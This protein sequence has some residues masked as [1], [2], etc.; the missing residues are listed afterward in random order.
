MFFRRKSTGSITHKVAAGKERSVGLRSAKITVGK[1]KKSTIKLEGSYISENHAVVDRTSDGDWKIE[2]LSPN[3]VIVNGSKVESAVLRNGD[4]IQ[5][6]SDNVLTIRGLSERDGSPPQEEAADDIAEQESAEGKSSSNNWLYM[7]AG[8]IYLLFFGYIAAVYFGDGQLLGYKKQDAH[9]SL[10]SLELAADES[11]VYLAD[12]TG[13]EVDR[14]DT[15]GSDVN[16][17]FL[18]EYSFDQFDSLNSSKEKRLWLKN[19]M[20]SVRLRLR[21]AYWLDQQGRVREAIAVLQDVTR[22]LPDFENPTTRY[23]LSAIV[24]LQQKVNYE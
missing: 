19:M 7:V 9:L 17:Q 10:N 6:G 23:A 12:K 16:E 5:I 14:S 2:N 24:E 18:R 13:I 3:G 8:V 11:L 21:N 4:R 15:T 22:K 20:T 1:S